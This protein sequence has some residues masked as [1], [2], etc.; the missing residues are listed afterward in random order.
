[1]INN[2]LTLIIFVI[3][4][5][6][7]AYGSSIEEQYYLKRTGSKL[8]HFDWRL[9]RGKD[10][11]LVTILGEER[12][13]TRMKNDFSTQSWSVEDPSVGTVIDVIRRDDTII[14]D[15][16]FKGKEFNRTITI[17]SSPW[18]QALSFSLRQFTNQS[19]KHIEF[20]SIRP[21]TLEVHRLQVV[22]ETDELLNINGVSSEVIKL[23]IQLTGL[24]SVFWSCYYWLRKTDGLFVRYEGPSGPPGWPLTTVDLIDTPTQAKLGGDSRQTQ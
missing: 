15:G 5:T 14:F 3:V 10:L 16:M 4:T 6:S 8:I 21:D 19:Y 12:D 20:W 7:T 1:M 18:Y 13:T 24:K 22:R 11:K 23:K 2:C 9:E 17:D